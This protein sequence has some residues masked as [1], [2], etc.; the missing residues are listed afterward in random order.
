L[1]AVGPA[2][3]ATD[4]G[5]TDAVGTRDIAMRA[6]LKLNLPVAVIDPEIGGSFKAASSFGI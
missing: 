2:R 3:L 5:A 6:I 1:P 4:I